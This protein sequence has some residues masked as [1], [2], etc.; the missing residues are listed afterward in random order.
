[1]LRVAADHPVRVMFPMVATIDEL[2][3][4][5][6]LLRRARAELASD[7]TLEVGIMVEVPAAALLAA[8]LAPSR[9]LL[10]DR[11]ERPHAIHA[12]G[13]PRERARRGICPTRCTRR[14]CA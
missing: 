5:L 6:A 12:G 3:A 9:R 7:A 2:D 1:M 13:R 4:A 14:S 10:L 8:A 11:D